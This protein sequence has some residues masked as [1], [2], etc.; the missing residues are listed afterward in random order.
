MRILILFLFTIKLS[1]GFSQSFG[2]ISEE[3]I[4]G[5][6]NSAIFNDGKKKVVHD[7]L[8]LNYY[9]LK[10]CY[11]KD[12]LLIANFD[13]LINELM[14]DTLKY[15][16]D[17]ADILFIKEQLSKNKLVVWDD[18]KLNRKI[19]V[20]SSKF[21]AMDYS[22][23]LFSRDKKT[24]IMGIPGPWGYRVYHWNYRTNSWEMIDHIQTGT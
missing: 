19:K 10:H 5:F 22:L 17:S 8:R 7:S 3:D 11:N 2:K 1:T 24:V 14:Q 6:M 15:F 23:P 18:E 20:K 13:C 4:Y 9:E 21:L 16:I 12:S